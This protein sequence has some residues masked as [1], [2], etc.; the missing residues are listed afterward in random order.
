MAS[1]TSLVFNLVA[2]DRASAAIGQ[3]KEKLSTA[4]A[5]ISAGVAGAL[6]AGVAASMDMSAA[7]DKLAA[8]LALGP[9]QAAAMAKT[10]ANVF[11]AGWGESATDVNEAIRGVYQQIGDTSQAKG[12]IEG[13]TSKVMA[14]SQTFDQ[15][16]GGTSAA[17]GQMI[18]TGLA[19]NADEALDI[20]TRGFQSGADK[21]GDLLDTMNE[22]GT[23]F[24]K[25]G[26]DGQMATGLLAQGLKAGARDADLVADAIKE[27]SIRAIDG[28][29][30]T[31]DGF[32]AIGLSAK[33]MATQIAKGG[34]SASAALDLTLDKLRAMKDPVAQAAAA[35]QLFGTQSE[36]LGK[37]LFALDP[38]SAVAALGDVAGA[39][40]K[41]AKTVGDNPSAALERF[42]REAMVK[43]AEVGGTLVQFGT[44]HA[45]WIQPLAITLGAV[46]AAILV[47]QGAVMAWTAAQAAWTAVQTVATGAQWLWNAA[48][49]ANPIGLIIIG[50][51]ALVAGIVLLWQHSEAFRGIMTAVWGA[52]WGAI[53]SVWDWVSSN[54]PLLLGILTGPIGWAVLVIMR[55]WDDIKGGIASVVAW[56]SDLPGKAGSA[57]SGL[58]SILLAPFTYAFNA[59]ARHWNGTVGGLSFTTPDWIPGIGGK[60]FS[61]PKIPML[62]KGG[63]LTSGG[64]VL[65]GDAGPELLDLPGGATV[66]PLARSAGVA[67]GTG[68]VVIDVTGADADM[69]RLIRRI[70]RI[71]GRNSVQTAFNT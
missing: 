24:R 39:A 25:F 15:D 21:A 27:F 11:K 41:M 68:R 14:L 60:G 56:V 50:V 71:D 61:M 19:K 48:L 9:E 22:Y 53:K 54:W 16:L 67:S 43:L 31:A 46:A 47:I 28:S 40:D 7:S 2:R 30:S 44:E 70:V 33:T 13:V 20:L 34:P 69:K 51:I 37:A 8:Q 55:Y 58:G 12:G 29:T 45:A 38:S 63:H 18:K 66:S 64:T 1:D 23:Q 10:S 62:A 26:I 59:I 4:A 57:L 3:M 17:V 65:V 42:K 5:G 32:K 36:D 35:T 49:A 52:V 6:G